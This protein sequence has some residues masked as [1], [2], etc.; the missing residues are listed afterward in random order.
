MDVQLEKK[1]HG[2]ALIEHGDDRRVDLGLR[3]EDVHQRIAHL[4]SKHLSGELNGLEDNVGCDSHS[5]ANQEFAEHQ[6]GPLA[7]RMLCE[8]TSYGGIEHERKRQH[9]NRL[10]AGRNGHTA[11]ERR[12]EHEA[13]QAHT[14]GEHAGDDRNERNLDHCR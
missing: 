10:D 8:S 14:D 13:R 9:Q 7:E 4:N 11:E 3:V 2:D 12:K 5:S 1:Q 6:E